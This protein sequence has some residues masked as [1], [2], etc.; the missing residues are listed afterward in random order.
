MA[1][2]KKGKGKGK[3]G[4]Q[5][6]RTK[7]AP[8]GGGGP[9]PSPAAAPGPAEAGESSQPEPSSVPQQGA[10][11]PEAA[12]APEAGDRGA[13]A[14]LRSRPD[15]NGRRV[16]VRGPAPGKDGAPRLA[17]RLLFGAGAGTVLKVKAANLDLDRDRVLDPAMATLVA[18][19]QALAPGAPPP[20]E[21]RDWAGGLPIE[22]LA[23]IAET[24]V[25]RTEAGWAAYL[26]QGLHWPEKTVQEE[27]E[28]RERD[29]NCL[30]VFAMVCRGWRKAQLKVGARCAPG[31]GRTWPCRG[32]WRWRS[33][34]W[35]RGAPGRGEVSPWLIALPS[36]DT[37]SW[38][39]G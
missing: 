1:P 37:S 5:G 33:G 22:V 31:L 36:T 2:K 13:L 25:A 16:E 21:R 20:E 7:V 39:C 34:R 27:M 3:K 26:N 19:M 23:K 32:A 38:W 35:R 29:G 4:G 24:H 17:V 12:P 6:Q 18:E 14:G 15:L 8:S 30:F 28:K 11:P 9:G 10:P